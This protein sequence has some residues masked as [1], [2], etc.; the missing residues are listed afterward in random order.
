MDTP[1]LLEQA[2]TALAPLLVAVLTLASAY[3]ARLINAK[4][5]NEFARGALLR[6]NDAVATIVRETQQTTIDD[7]KDAAKDGKVD[8]AELDDIQA[9]AADRVRAYLGKRGIAEVERVFDRDQIEAVIKSKIE[10]AVLDLN[11]RR[12]T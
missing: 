11:D 7:L 6:L 1:T 2:I 12:T 10:A 5:R 8:K 3:A 4:V 9:Q